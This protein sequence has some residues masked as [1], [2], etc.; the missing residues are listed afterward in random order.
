[1]EYEFSYSYYSSHFTPIDVD[2]ED[3]R[4]GGENVDSLATRI[5]DAKYDQVN[6]HDFAFNQQQ[7]LLDQC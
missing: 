5:L 3:N 2:L 1:M 6:I 7:H 4:L